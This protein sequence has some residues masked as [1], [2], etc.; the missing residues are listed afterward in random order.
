MNIPNCFPENPLAN[1]PPI[2]MEFPDVLVH[3]VEWRE[4]CAAT[5]PT[6]IPIREFE[7]THVCSEC[8]N[9]RAPRVEHE[10]QRTSVVPLPGLV[11]V[12]AVRQALRPLS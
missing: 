3:Q 2:A 4:V 5:K 6:L 9:T 7:A 11:R 10:A 12:R 8:W 1:I